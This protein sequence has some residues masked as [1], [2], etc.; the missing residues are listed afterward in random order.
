MANTMTLISSVTVGAGGASS[1]DFTSIPNTYTDLV[2]KISGRTSAAVVNSGIYIKFN[3]STTSYQSRNLY[4]TTGTSAT[5]NNSAD[6]YAGDINGGSST[7]NVF[8]NWEVYIP[9]YAGS[10]NKSYSI[11][12]AAENNSN[13]TGLGFTAGLWSNTSAITSVSLTNVTFVQY[14]SA[15]LYGVKNA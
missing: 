13:P 5:T 1:I 10:S 9:N 4:T 7:A 3:G 8:G 15:T 14:S 12:Y 11:D 2:L 6:N